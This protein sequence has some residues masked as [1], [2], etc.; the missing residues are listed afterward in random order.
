M[1]QYQT[2]FAL[3]NEGQIVP[4]TKV[5][6]RNSAPAVSSGSDKI[7]FQDFAERWHSQRLKNT[8]AHHLA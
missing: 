3:M 7:A 6:R 5:R 2:I 8:G 4:F 1:L